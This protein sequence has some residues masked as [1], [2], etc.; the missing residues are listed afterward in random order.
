M[1][2]RRVVVY[3]AFHVLHIR[4]FKSGQGLAPVRTR[5]A[6]SRYRTWRAGIPLHAMAGA[7]DEYTVASGGKAYGKEGG[8][9]CGVGTGDLGTLGNAIGALDGD[10]LSRWEDGIALYFHCVWMI[11]RRGFDRM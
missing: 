1:K 5:A 4:C 2:I 10:L 11:G 7:R 9:Y 6:R 8:M 3:L